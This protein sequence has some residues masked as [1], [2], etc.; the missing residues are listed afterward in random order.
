M[1]LYI[2]TI[3]ASSVLRRRFEA[4]D[5]FSEHAQAPA[6]LFPPA[7]V[8]IFIFC[9]QDEDLLSGQHHFEAADV[10]ADEQEEAQEDIKIAAELGL[11]M[12]LSFHAVLLQLPSQSGGEARRQTIT[13]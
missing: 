4:E 6:Q 3:F 12:F 5:I 7:V 1:S 2:W 13:A 11:N 8:A 10:D 9:C